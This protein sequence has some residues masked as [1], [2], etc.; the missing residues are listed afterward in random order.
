MKSL[1]VFI[2]MLLATAC[3]KTELISKENCPACFESILNQVSP[4]LEIWR[5]V[6][7][8]QLVYLA[9][10]DCCDQYDRVYTS[11]CTLICAPSGGI[12]GKGDDKCSDFYDKATHGLLVWKKGN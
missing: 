11:D 5:Y 9:I 1:L 10:S 12:T 3:D 2:L 8:N 6:Y 7:N 4:P